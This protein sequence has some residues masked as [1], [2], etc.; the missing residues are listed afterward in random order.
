MA[1]V[2]IWDFAGQYVFYAT[3]QVFLSRRAVYLLV[4]DISKHVEDT[5]KDD[6]CFLDSKGVQTLENIRW[7]LQVIY[8]DRLHDLNS[9]LPVPI[10]RE[11]ELELFL[12]FHHESGN[13]LYY[14]DDK[15]S[16]TIVLDPQWLIDA[17]KSLITAKMF[18]CRKPN[19][20]KKWIQFDQS[21]ILT[22]ELVDA[23]WKQDESSTFKEY[24]ELLL[25]YLEKLGFI[26][27]PRQQS[28]EIGE[29]NY[30]FAPC[31]LKTSPPEDLLVCSDCKNRR[32]TSVLC[33][34]T[35]SG[36]LPTAVFNKLL[37]ACIDKWPIS[38]L[39]KKNLVF[40]GC[41]VFDLE[42]NHKL[43]VYFFD[44]II[45]IWI[46][47]YSTT[48]EEPST[49]L[50]QH[51]HEFVSEFLKNRM[52]ITSGIEVFLRCNQSNIHNNDNL[53]ELENMS[54][55][56]EVVCN[57]EPVHHV[58]RTNELIKYWLYSDS[59]HQLDELTEKELNRMA[60][61][62]GKEYQSLGIELGLSNAEIEHICLDYKAT[63]DRIRGILL[64]WKD[65][66]VGNA[67]L[68]VLVNAMNVVGID[69]VTVIET[70]K[71]K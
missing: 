70:A 30:Y 9:T 49:C 3:H 33:F 44:H 62:I 5:V 63:V 32:S 31:V 52:R 67:T 6:D 40:C 61:H 34:T 36:F 28:D 53:F 13:I 18:C 23:I 10:E 46:T 29:I 68:E 12:R 45:N 7:N 25:E 43:Y 51:V 47:K 37:A 4:T 11:E 35:T 65:Q 59:D 27:K 50:C 20:F 66:N 15:L 39:N 17:F 71:E 56:Q 69:A 38:K 22:R 19:I 57:T 24:D 8:K 16:D 26:S 2:S 1:D 60:L 14:S 58:H 55:K 54:G 48:D 41:G 42:D 21:A 64:K